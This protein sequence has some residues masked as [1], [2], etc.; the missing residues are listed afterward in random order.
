MIDPPHSRRNVYRDDR[1]PQR[2]DRYPFHA[3]GRWGDPMA[4]DYDRPVYDHRGI[5]RRNVPR[6]GRGYRDD[7]GRYGPDRLSA[8]ETGIA[9]HSHMALRH[10]HPSWYDDPGRVLRTIK[11]FFETRDPRW[12]GSLLFE[13]NGRSMITP[14]SSAWDLRWTEERRPPVDHVVS[15]MD[16]VARHVDPRLSPVDD[17]EMRRP[18]LALARYSRHQRHGATSTWGRENAEASYRP[19]SGELGGPSRSLTSSPSLYSER[20]FHARVRSAS[21][22]AFPTA[23]TSPRATPGS[24]NASHNGVGV[25]QVYSSRY[26]ADRRS[27]QVL[28][29]SSRYSSHQHYD[30]VPPPRRA[31]SINDF[32]TDHGAMVGSRTL[33]PDSV[34]GLQSR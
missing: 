27:D 22:R 16:T 20:A 3:D 32:S 30:L 21:P 5:P 11:P 4:P 24:W 17:F 1:Y 34:R 29:P 13:E 28:S 23:S 8:W 19:Y 18:G 14:V 9:E 10:R 25:G 12:G 33:P 7:S 2:S 31:F 6:D 15:H 26:V